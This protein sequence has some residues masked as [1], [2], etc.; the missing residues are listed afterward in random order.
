MRGLARC[1]HHEMFNPLIILSISPSLSPPA[2]PSKQVTPTPCPRLFSP[3][4][5]RPFVPSLHHTSRFNTTPDIID[6]CDFE[7]FRGQGFYQILVDPVGHIFLINTYI[8]KR[9][10]IIFQ[11]FEFDNFFVGDIFN[12]NTRNIRETAVGT[13]CAEFRII[14]C[15][16]LFFS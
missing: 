1:T 9:D 5:P 15:N 16:N 10:K 3:S 8:S 14:Q 11:G 13:D 6:G 2:T 12:G 7:F 4:N